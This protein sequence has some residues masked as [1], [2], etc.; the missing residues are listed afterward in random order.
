MVPAPPPALLLEPPA[1][2]AST[3]LPS[4]AVL[5]A[6]AEEGRLAAVPPQAPRLPA[7]VGA[8]GLQQPGAHPWQES[9][10][11]LVA[12]SSSGGKV[13]RSA[14]GLGTGAGPSGWTGARGAWPEWHL[15]GAPLPSPRKSAQAKV[16]GCS[17]HLSTLTF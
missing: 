7:G 1:L 16:G 6:P 15:L 13:G 12:K 11:L 10:C 3:E 8:L 2:S 17:L 5:P 4:S 14:V 9:T